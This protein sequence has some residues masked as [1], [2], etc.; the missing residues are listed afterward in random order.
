MFNF[1]DTSTIPLSKTVECVV[2]VMSTITLV[3]QL[4][5]HGLHYITFMQHYTSNTTLVSL[6]KT[7]RCGYMQASSCHREGPGMMYTSLCV[8]AFSTMSHRKKTFMYKSH[9]TTPQ[10]LPVCSCLAALYS[11]WLKVSEVCRETS[12]CCLKEETVPI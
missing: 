4:D 6:H 5:D 8:L 3:L 1:V 10:S 11:A 9:Q 7:C 12:Y 2:E